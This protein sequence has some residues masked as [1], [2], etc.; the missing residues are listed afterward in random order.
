[1]LFKEQLTE[2]C[3]EC[4]TGQ[5]EKVD[6]V[7]PYCQIEYLEFSVERGEWIRIVGCTYVFAIYI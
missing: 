5:G 2:C 6:D 1:M 4:C 7:H 3:I